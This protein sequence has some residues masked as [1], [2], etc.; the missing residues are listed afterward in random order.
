MDFESV[1]P[2]PPE[3]LVHIQ[4]GAL[5]WQSIDLRWK[6]MSLS[7]IGLGSA[8][9]TTYDRAQRTIELCDRATDIVSAAR[10]HFGAYQNRMEHAMAIDDYTAENTQ[11]AESRIRDTDMAKESVE[12]NKHSI[13]Q[14]AGSS[15][16]TQANQSP[17][18]VLQL[19][20]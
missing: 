9:V 14:Q 3:K 4:A 11:A 18:G 19:L 12:Y 16:L 10:A 20:Q 17:Y 8:N 13:L 1:T 6:G 7:S 2:P 15:V 5:P